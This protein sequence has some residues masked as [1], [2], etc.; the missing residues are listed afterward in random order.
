MLPRLPVA[1]DLLR[2]RPFTTPRRWVARAKNRARTRAANHKGGSL[3][4]ELSCK[5][6]CRLCL[7]PLLRRLGTVGGLR[8][9]REHNQGHADLLR[10]RLQEILRRLRAAVRGFEP[11]HAQG[12]ARPVAG[13]R[14]S[15]GQGW[16]SLASR[17][18]QD[19]S[20]GERALS[21]QR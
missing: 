15:T 1:E 6:A 2:A 11:V 20:K 21:Q 19:Q 16:K 12:R 13:L 7:D 4:D 5:T 14:A 10:Q 8:T 9:G 17:C 3:N 18:G